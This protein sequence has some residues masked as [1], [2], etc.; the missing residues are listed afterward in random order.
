MFDIER[1]FKLSSNSIKDDDTIEMD[2][3][4]NAYEELSKYVRRPDKLIL[5]HYWFFCSQQI[6]FFLTT[7]ISLINN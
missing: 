2:E 6:L 1:L 3:Y 4:I 5:T 7:S